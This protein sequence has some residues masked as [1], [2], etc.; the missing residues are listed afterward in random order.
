MFVAAKMIDEK[1]RER[2]K[3]FGHHLEDE[4]ISLLL[5]RVQHAQKRTKTCLQ[6]STPLQ[7]F[8]YILTCFPD[9]NQADEEK[10]EVM[11]E[12]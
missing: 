1:F 12:T 3:T 9:D 8:T 5:A 10:E 6:Q 7:W 4:E 2:S 11:K